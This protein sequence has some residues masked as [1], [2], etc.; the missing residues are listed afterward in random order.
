MNKKRR[1]WGLRKKIILF[2]SLLIIVPFLGLGLLKRLEVLLVDHLMNSL[3]TQAESMALF[4]QRSFQDTSVWNTSKQPLNNPIYVTTLTHDMV[5][6]G[7][8]DDWVQYQG[9]AADMGKNISLIMGRSTSGLVLK[10]EV[11]KPS[12]LYRQLD[13]PYDKSEQV[14]LFFQGNDGHIY[15]LYFSPAAPGRVKPYQHKTHSEVWVTEAYWQEVQGG[16]NLEVQLPYKFWRG[17]GLQVMQDNIMSTLSKDIALY[18]K[19]LRPLLW[20]EQHLEKTVSQLNTIQG[21]RIWILDQHGQLLARHGNI[22]RQFSLEAVN[23]IINFV[24]VPPQKDFIDPRARSIHFSMPFI[25]KVLAGEGPQK[26]REVITGTD[27]AMA[28]VAVPILHEEQPVGVVFLEETVAAVQIVQRRAFNI[29]LNS[30]FIIMSIIIGLLI[31]M[32]TRLARRIM[33]L[34]QAIHQATDEQGRITQI[35]STELGRDEVGELSSSFES[36]SRKLMGYHDYL[37]R[38]SE[39]LIHELRTP[40]AMMTSSLETLKLQLDDGHQSMLDNAEQGLSRLSSVIHRMGEAKRVEESIA[41]ADKGLLDMVDF[42]T[43]YVDLYRQTRC[44]T[45]SLAIHQGKKLDKQHFQKTDLIDDTIDDSITAQVMASP[46]LLAQMMDKLL[47]NAID[48]SEKE[49]PISITLNIEKEQVTLS[50][51][52]QGKC[53][54]EGVPVDVLFS[55]MVSLRQSL[56]MKET[57]LGLGL[58]IVRLIVQYHHGYYFAENLEKLPGVRLGVVFPMAKK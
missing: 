15:P 40:V 1:F 19:T 7:Y 2:S 26:Q 21:R 55:S 41:L 46:E 20:P 45:L 8:A 48:F 16:Y 49:M 3:Q 27:M 38:L 34:N 32:I 57:H 33:R 39:R 54:P 10:V 56:S 53:L 6:D 52:N 14:I 44:S 35:V 22:Y 17:I 25:Q 43:G 12:V 13:K 18:Q 50:V 36:M 30:V 24:F 51:I 58:Y 47:S 37:E 29:Y 28:M 4:L 23:P 9:F 11:R 31:I 5:I 42:M